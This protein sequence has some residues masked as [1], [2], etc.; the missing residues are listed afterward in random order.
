MR[1]S[2]I[3]SLFAELN[4]KISTLLTSLLLINGYGLTVRG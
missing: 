1:S 4:S 3:R 2:D